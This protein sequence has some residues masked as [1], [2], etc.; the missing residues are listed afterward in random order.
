M[1]AGKN[2]A[3]ASQMKRLL[4]ARKH[5]VRDL[6]EYTQEKDSS[7]F[8]GF[9]LARKASVSENNLDTY[10][11]DGGVVQELLDELFNPQDQ[12]NLRGRASA[13]STNDRRES[14]A[15]E[16]DEVSSDE[17]S[18]GDSFSENDAGEDGRAYT[19]DAYAVVDSAEDTVTSSLQRP[20]ALRKLGDDLDMNAVAAA[21]TALR[22]GKPVPGGTDNDRVVPHDVLCD[23][24]NDDAWVAEF[25]HLFPE[26]CGG[27]ED[28]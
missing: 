5:M 4:G 8:N 21:E 7:F 25:V 1:P 26:G 19:V 18:S 22:R 12:N 11:S 9:Y 14:E 24:H 2:K 10:R 17:E 16:Q 15:M 28:P 6:I 13:S 20:R 3:I 27:P 23:F